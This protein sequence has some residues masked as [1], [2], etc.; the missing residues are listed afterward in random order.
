M[1]IRKL[2]K[3]SLYTTLSVALLVCLLIATFAGSVWYN[4]K[5]KSE[6]QT[7]KIEERNIQFVLLT[8]I[9]GFEDRAWY[10]YK[11]EIN[12]PLTKA[13]KEGHNKEHVLFW[14][15]AEA[16]EQ[17]ENPILRIEK[18]KYLVFNRG[19]LDHSLYNFIENTVLVNEHSTYGQAVG[20]PDINIPY[21]KLDDFLHEWAYKNLH[22][23]IQ[24][25]IAK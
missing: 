20:K 17:Q 18:N 25:H 22:L 4:N 21:N 2:I 1:N 8:D 24:K 16:G 6:I 23:E 12:K 15:Y 10:V 19:G 14:N 3:Y 11:T 5:Y 13:Q 9:S 7:I